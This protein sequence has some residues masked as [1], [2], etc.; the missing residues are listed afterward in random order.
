MNKRKIAIFNIFGTLFILF[1]VLW[2]IIQLSLSVHINSVKA[3]A[4]FDSV[5]SSV[6]EDLFTG[7]KSESRTSNF[8]KLSNIALSSPPLK[9]L[10][11]SDS[12]GK[13][14]YLYAR[15]PNVINE[16][17]LEKNA[18]NIQ[19]I[20][21][22]K[23]IYL[24][25]FQQL[26]S[27]NYRVTAVFTILDEN[28][29]ILV[30]RISLLLIVLFLAASCFILLSY[31]ESDN[32]PAAEKT[33]SSGEEWKQEKSGIDGDGFSFEKITNELKR[34]ASFDQDMVLALIKVPEEILAM[35]K[36]MFE[37]L[38]T[39]AFSFSDMI[40]RYSDSLYAVIL[41][42]EDI[43][44]GISHIRDFDQNTAENMDMLNRYTILYGLSSRNGRLVEGEILFNEAYAALKRAEKEENANIIGFRPD[45]AK[46][47]EFLSKTQN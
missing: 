15:N 36:K 22:I 5:S 42:N 4:L 9:S 3:G 6:I 38:L 17:S 41:P 11:V 39:E 1:L 14:L 10:A 47:R 30:F 18:D 40:F 35:K 34:A 2:V 27:R 12:K 44:S 37:D 32:T 23:D 28:Q 21:R 16:S 46:Y 31:R 43:D 8:V 33:S 19:K 25:S 29:F 24:T 26:G 13:V 7:N 45:P 20:D